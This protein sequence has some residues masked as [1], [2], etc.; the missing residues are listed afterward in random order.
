[1]KKK[2][3]RRKKK[4]FTTPGDHSYQLLVERERERDKFING[5]HS[6]DNKDPDVLFSFFI[7]LGRIITG[8]DGLGT[9]RV[10][11]KV[12]FPSGNL[13]FLFLLDVQDSFV[14]CWFVFRMDF[15]GCVG[16]FFFFT[17]INYWL[18]P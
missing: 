16:F 13:C 7:T 1:V 12:E 3:G 14:F 9:R 18:R 15:Y 11:T 8:W 6:C 5:A 17:S 4:C 2:W 10:G